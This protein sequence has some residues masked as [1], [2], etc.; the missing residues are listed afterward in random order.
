[1][2]PS[3]AEPR[4]P[5]RDSLTHLGP[6]AGMGHL[7]IAAGFTAGL[8]LRVMAADLEPGTLST[9]MAV[10][11]AVGMSYTIPDEESRTESP[12]WR[13]PNRWSFQLGVVFITETTID[14]IAKTRLA[15]ARG[16]AEGQIYLLQASLKLASFEPVFLGARL[17]MDLELPVVL[18]VVNER[19][20]DPFLQYNAGLTLRWKTFP[21][22]RWIYTNSETGGGLTYS[23]Q[24]LQI[25]RQRHLG[26][27]RSH[28]EFYW[29]IQLMLAHPRHPRHQ[30]TFLV[31]H[32]SGGHIFHAGGSNSVGFGYRLLLGR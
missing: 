15:L 1:M 28:L 30:L 25:Q 7:L 27:S 5:S 2:Y 4:I 13:D 18:G 12:F 20:S 16:D 6:S 3:G 21:W 9:P 26:R 19:G 32:H 8:S 14:N 22:N 24:V 31:H 29:P 11:H 10:H 17:E 23:G